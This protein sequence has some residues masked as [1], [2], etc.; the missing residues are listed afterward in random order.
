M[1]STISSR[2]WNYDEGGKLTSEYI[3]ID[4]DHWT[5]IDYTYDAN[6][7]LIQTEQHDYAYRYETLVDEFVDEAAPNLSSELWKSHTFNLDKSAYVRMT[8]IFILNDAATNGT[9]NPDR[10]KFEIDTLS[11][12][13]RSGSSSYYAN[14]ERTCVIGRTLDPGSHTYRILA[15]QTPYLKSVL[16]TAR[17]TDETVTVTSY[18]TQ[19]NITG[20]IVTYPDGSVAEYDAQGNIKPEKFI[21]SEAEEILSGVVIVAELPYVSLRQ[22]RLRGVELPV[23]HLA[24]VV[25][26]IGPPQHLDLFAE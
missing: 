14:Q 21:V 22:R 5:R 2:T 10:L 3:R 1:Y 25:G 20:S 8:P 11:Y 16:I 19:G 13:W 24:D 9:P 18:D 12:S 15:D 7:N 4:S 6:D 23:V 26:M 17:Y